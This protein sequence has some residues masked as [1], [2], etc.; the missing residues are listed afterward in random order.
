MATSTSAESLH[1]K[2]KHVIVVGFPWGSDV[3]EAARAPSVCSIA[4]PAR[5]T[6]GDLPGGPWVNSTIR[7]RVTSG[8]WLSR[9]GASPQSHPAGLLCWSMSQQDA[10]R[11]ALAESRSRGRS[12]SGWIYETKGVNT[13]T[14]KLIQGPIDSA[15]MRPCLLEVS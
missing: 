15:N 1:T 14:Y 7:D 10:A 5:L 11:P 2:A 8:D 12:E 6:T 4:A 13:L 9:P 3:A